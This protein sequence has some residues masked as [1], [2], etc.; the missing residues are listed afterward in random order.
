MSRIAL[1]EVVANF[2]E[3]IDEI[4]SIFGASKGSRSVRKFSIEYCPHEDGCLISIWD[5]WNRFL[6]SLTLASVAA[7]T[8]GLRG[9]TYT[10][11]VIFSEEAAL[12]HLVQNKRG[13]AYR[14]IGGEPY[15]YNINHL[16]DI[17]ATL[18][19]P[20]A[21]QIVNA[22][23]STT[24]T[25]GPTSVANPLEEIRVHRNFSAHKST[26]L[27]AEINSYS[28]DSARSFS[29]RLRSRRRGVEAFHEWTECLLALAFAAAQ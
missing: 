22:I 13:K 8:T 16:I 4:D 3:E 24:V 27:L 21:S 1:H 7:E 26:G 15:W 25:L 2:K 20:N 19:A 5:A 14:I 17:L 29:A 28:S 18:G 10:P 6:R 11:T 12:R 9:V 23:S